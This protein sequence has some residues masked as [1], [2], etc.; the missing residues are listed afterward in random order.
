MFTPDGATFPAG[1]FT[2]RERAEQWIERVGAVGLLGEYVLDAAAY[3]VLTSAGMFTP[4]TEAQMTDA[5]QARFTTP[6]DHWHYGL[7]EVI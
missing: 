1:V 7:D 3:D 6:V 2:T 5:Y 4:R